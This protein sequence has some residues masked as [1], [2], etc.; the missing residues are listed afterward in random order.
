MPPA[1]RGAG[2]ERTGRPVTTA[3]QRGGGFSLIEMIVVLAIIGILASVVTVNVVQYVARARREGTRLQM[4]ELRTALTAF[5]VA[6]GFYPTTEQGLEALVR[7]PRGVPALRDY[8][9]DG[10]LQGGVVP[11]DGWG[12]EIVYLSPG[13]RGETYEIISYGADGRPGGTGD[14]EDIVIA[15]GAPSR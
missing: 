11:R 2:R 15:E 6:H 13:R 8:P 14:D 3:R 4:Q 12:N 5:H 1:P 7:P 9:R 10:Y